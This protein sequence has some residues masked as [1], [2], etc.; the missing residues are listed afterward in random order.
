MD[1]SCPGSLRIRGEQTAV[2]WRIIQSVLPQ[3]ISNLYLG[4]RWFPILFVAAPY[5]KY[6]WEW[7]VELWI[8][9]GK[10]QSNDFIIGKSAWVC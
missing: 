3:C 5:E 6:V 7:I 10:D 8:V 4:F 9:Q 1:A 2:Y